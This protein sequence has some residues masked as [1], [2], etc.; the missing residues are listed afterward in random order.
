MCHDVCESELVGVRNVACVCPLGALR[1]NRLECAGPTETHWYGGGG[2]T[3]VVEEK[4]KKR[5]GQVAGEERKRGVGG[6]HHNRITPHTFYSSLLP[7]SS[8][9]S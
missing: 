8:H 3:G 9:H 2:Q 1:Q 7:S 4:K 5:R 6:C